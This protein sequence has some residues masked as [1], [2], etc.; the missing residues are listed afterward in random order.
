[1]SD[2]DEYGQHRYG[3]A[4]KKLRKRWAPKVAAGKARCWRCGRAI[5][6]GARWDLGHVVGGGRHPEHASCN[7]RTV[8][9]LKQQL[10]WEPEQRFD[11]GEPAERWSRHWYGGFDSRCPRCRKT[12]EPCAV[13][14]RLV[15]D[16]AA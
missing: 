13:A 15:A 16:E 4:H 14:L 1:M 5:M 12:G 2:H 7:R 11:P 3:Y 10:A 6:P 9:H 8:S